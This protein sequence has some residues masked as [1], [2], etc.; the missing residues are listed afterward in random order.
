[1]ATHSSILAGEIPWTEEPGGLQYMGLQKLG[2]TQQLNHHRITCVISVYV[3]KAE[4]IQKLV[5]GFFLKRQFVDWYKGTRERDTHCTVYSF[6][7]LVPE[8][9]S[10]T[11]FEKYLLP[12]AIRVCIFAMCVLVAQSCLTLCDPMDCSPPGPSIHEILQ[13]RTLEW[14]AISFSSIFAISGL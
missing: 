1:M 11:R 3:I 14:V 12:Y 9:D 5:T 8:S 4:Y 6:L 10:S 13:I 7:N 2:M